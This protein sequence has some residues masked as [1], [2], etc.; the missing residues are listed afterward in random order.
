QAERLAAGY[1]AQFRER[2]DAILPV[3]RAIGFEVGRQRATLYLW[4]PLPDGVASATFQKRALEDVGVVT[5]PGSALG[6]GAEGLFR[7]A[8]TV[9]APRLIEATER[10]GKVLAAV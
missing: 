7:C 1:V 4:I 3:L 8:V 6:A 9:P 10:L 5:L 2:R